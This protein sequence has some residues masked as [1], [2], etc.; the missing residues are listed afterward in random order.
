MRATAAHRVRRR[1]C[2]SIR[3]PR[4]VSPSAS[5]AFFKWMIRSLAAASLLGGATSSWCGTVLA[6][7]ATDP[8]AAKKDEP[9]SSIEAIEQHIKELRTQYAAK[10]DDKLK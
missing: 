10:P 8:P 2:F 7:A 1:S 6:Q 3:R 9:Q 4:M 5:H